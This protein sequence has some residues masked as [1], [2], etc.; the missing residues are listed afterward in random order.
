[1]DIPGRPDEI[2]TPKQWNLIGLSMT[3]LP[4]ALSPCSI[5]LPPSSH[6]TFIP[7]SPQKKHISKVL[8]SSTCCKEAI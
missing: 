4:P 1:M 7:P 5:L 2:Q 3:T 6:C 8:F